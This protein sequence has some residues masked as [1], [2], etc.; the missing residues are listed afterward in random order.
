[1]VLL[2]RDRYVQVGAGF[3][4]AWQLR[5]VEYGFGTLGYDP[6]RYVLVRLF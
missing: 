1:M 3:G 2:G 6:V 4:S 5:K